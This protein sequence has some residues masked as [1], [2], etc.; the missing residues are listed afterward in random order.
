MAL[1]DAIERLITEHGS[2]AILRERL[3]F[4]GEQAKT[5]EKENV[6]LKKRVT[7]LEKLTGSLASQ[8]QSKTKEAEFIEHRGAYFKR[9]P[10]GS[11]HRAV[12]CPICRNPT[13]SLMD[14]LP[15]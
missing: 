5:L 1:T 11:Y 6:D 7:E 13:G 15:Y 3:L 10:D 8:L 2:A 9:K 14:Q 12:Y 4:L